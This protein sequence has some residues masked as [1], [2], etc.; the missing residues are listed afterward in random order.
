MARTPSVASYLSADQVMQRIKGTVG[1]WR[2]QKWLVIYNLLVDPRPLMEIACHLGLA[3]QTVRNLVSQYN[4]LGPEAIEGPGKGGRRRAYM[5][6]KEEAEFIEQF[7]ERA[8]TGK[9]ATVTEIK[10]AWEKTLGHSVHK[11]TVYR[12]LRRHGWRKIVPR[13]FHVQAKDK[14][15]E[16]FK[17][18][19]L[20]K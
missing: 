13:P 18:T 4:R 16:E 7:F 3:W 1:F 10:R 6:L 19:S 8:S 11:T 5:D 17:K 15:Q 20:K 9:I 14:E 12:L 2:V